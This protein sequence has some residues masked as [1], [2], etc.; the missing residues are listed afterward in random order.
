MN[1]RETANPNG[2]AYIIHTSGST[3][4][5]KGVVV[6][7]RP[8]INLI[9][10]VNNTFHINETD[11]VLAVASICFDLSVYDIFGLLAAGGSICLI[12]KEELQDPQ[13]MLKL[14]KDESITFWNSAPPVLNQLVHSCEL[15]SLT[16]I[17]EKLRLIFLS[18]D[19]I[20]VDLPNRLKIHFPQAQVISLGGATEATVWSNYYPI[21]IINPNWKSIPYGRPIQ[22]AKYY[23]LDEQLN[24]CAIGVTGELYI[25]G[26]C[27][28]M[29]Y[30]NASD[31][32]N[33]RF[34][35]NPFRNDKDKALGRN[36]RIYRTGDL[37]RYFSDGNIEFLGRKDHQVKIR[38]FRVEC[39][40]IEAVLHKHPSVRDAV[41]MVNETPEGKQLVAYIV[42]K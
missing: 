3:G 14:I 5:P 28:A 36:F 27:L 23:I 20:P 16:C 4:K 6:Q 1:L 24:P 26:E 32:D 22:N 34:M 25:G 39:G 7:H 13:I 19:W 9:E 38:G 11:R 31:E 30:R 42:P 15:N 8:V 17:S 2:I 12:S 41:V 29:G 37:A 10:W 33:A 21:S 35:D 40:E 18:G